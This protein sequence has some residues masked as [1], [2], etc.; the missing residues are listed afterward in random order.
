MVLRAWDAGMLA[1]TAAIF[2]MRDGHI[3]DGGKIVLRVDDVAAFE[4]QV[5]ASLAE[6]G[7][8]D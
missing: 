4:Q 3:A 6:S 5:V 1:A 8:G 7:K 2:A